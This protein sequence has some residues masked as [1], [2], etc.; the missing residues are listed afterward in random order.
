VYEPCVLGD[1]NCSSI[2][3]KAIFN[4]VELGCVHQ[5]VKSGSPRVAFGHRGQCSR[6]FVNCP[7]EHGG[8]N[9][10]HCFDEFLSLVRKAIWSC[11]RTPSDNDYRPSTRATWAFSARRYATPASTAPAY[12]LRLGVP[13][14]RVSS[15]REQQFMP[16][17][18]P[19]QHNVRVLG[20]MEQA[21]GGSTR[22]RRPRR[23]GCRCG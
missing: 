6:F 16:Q 7:Q 20:Q 1:I 2:A 18:E 17:D 12:L 21:G 9:I 19:G 3:A 15:A 14:G 13:E 4:F 11:L 10:L 5:V 22:E 8:A 23:E